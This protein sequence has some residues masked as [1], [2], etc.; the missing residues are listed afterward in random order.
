MKE[1]AIAKINKIGKISSV[2]SLIAK[3][4]V[5]IGIVATIL[6]AVICF[7][8]PETMVKVST[9]GDLVTE[10]DLSGLGISMS[11]EEVLAAQE[12][13]TIEMAGAEHS[14][15]ESEITGNKVIMRGPLEDMSFT[16]RDIAKICVLALVLLIMT[17]ITLLFVGALCKA[18]RDCESPFEENVIKKM[19]HLA[20]CLIPWAV[21]STV[22]QS[23][24]DS[25]MNHKFSFSV[26]VDLGVVLV[27]LVVLILTYI[28]KY[29]AVLQQESDETL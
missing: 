3:I 4:L 11:E 23:I 26:T 2:V 14:F 9:V 27:V 17:F 8:L 13:L 7:V 5:G 21:I 6:G 1:Q 12:S 29:G 25:I 19:H 10:V 18:F 24:A 22:T 16:M 20:V 15:T 28:F